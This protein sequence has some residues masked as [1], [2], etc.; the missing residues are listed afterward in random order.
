MQCFINIYEIINA[1]QISERLMYSYDVDRMFFVCE[2][3][4]L[5]FLQQATVT[6]LSYITG[7]F[8]SV[9]SPEKNNFFIM[10]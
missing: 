2:S 6:L 5:T 3:C 8:Q 4:T 1:L 10:Y 9:V 7:H